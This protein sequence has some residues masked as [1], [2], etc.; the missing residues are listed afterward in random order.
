MLPIYLKYLIYFFS[1]SILI[2]VI[3]HIAEKRSRKTAGILMCLPVITFLS[4]LF[5]AISQGTDFSSR[6]AVWNPIGGIADL[7]YMGL[8][9]LGINLQEYIGKK[10]MRNDRIN[11]YIEL[12]WGLISGFTGYFICIAILSRFPIKSGW[13]SLFALWMAA[14]VFY[15]F[16]KRLREDELSISSHTS[17]NEIVLRGFF[18]GSAVAS[19]VILGDLFGYKWGGIFSSFPGTITPVLILLHL[20]NGKEIIPGVIKSAP[21]GLSATGLYSCMVWIMYPAYGIVAGTLASY[22]IVFCFL[23]VISY[24][25]PYLKKSDNYP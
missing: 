5:L 19:V 11:K 4:L 1:G 6:A 22:F 8:F 16:F 18:G 13:S 7:V 17:M 23:L 25:P 3:T 20:K 2:I 24:V 15:F 14:I 9:A 21:I 12:L 10:G